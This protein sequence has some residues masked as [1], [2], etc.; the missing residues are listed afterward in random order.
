MILSPLGTGSEDDGPVGRS[1]L[2]WG[3]DG[4]SWVITPVISHGLVF[5]LIND[6]FVTGV[7]SGFGVTALA[8]TTLPSV[9]AT[10]CSP[11]L[12]VQSEPCAVMPPLLHDPPLDWH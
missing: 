9:R 5:I 8:L 12:K 6:D 1:L 4:V 3:F 11:E 10:T 2:V 7:L